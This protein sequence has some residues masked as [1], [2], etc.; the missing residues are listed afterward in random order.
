MNDN[1]PETLPWISHETRTRWLLQRM[2]ILRGNP[3]FVPA[4]ADYAQGIVRIFEGKYMANKVMANLARQV[5]CMSVLALHFN[6]NERHHGAVL[7]CIQ[8]LTS[9]LGLCSPNT[10]A[11]T[12]D[13]LENI[14]LVTRVQDES[15]HRNHLI[16]PTDKLIRG[17]SAIVGVALVAVDRLFPMRRYRDL[18]EGAGDFMERY[19]ASSL[20][21]LLN[22]STLI[23]NLRGSRLFFTSDS[24]WMLL[25]KLMAL[26]QSQD[27]T[28]GNTVRFPFDEIGDLYG[29]S[30]TH[31]RRLMKKVEAEGLVRLHSDGGRKIEILPALNEI[32]EN[33]VAAR[34]AKTQFD[35]HLANRDYDLLPMDR[36]YEGFTT[37]P[38]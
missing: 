6:R 32:F 18:V 13:L 16:L 29:V 27:S 31:V 33:V 28:N 21:S 25:C 5:I 37:V 4:A 38:A 14:G 19:F 12:I 34:V 8:S 11:A 30:R 2:S 1:M 10:T 26:R 3:N 17:T 23:P 7:S 35:L 15:D 24:G 22:I 20:H 36:G 9:A